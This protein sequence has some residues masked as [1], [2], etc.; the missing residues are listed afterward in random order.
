MK[1]KAAPFT[2]KDMPDKKAKKK[3]VKKVVK[4]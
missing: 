3:L 2:K 4:K 1:N